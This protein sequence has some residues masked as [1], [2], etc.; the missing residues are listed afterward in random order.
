MNNETW[1]PVAGYAGLYEVS[2][3]GRVRRVNG[4]VLRLSPHM[5]GGLMAYLFRDGE[6]RSFLAHRLVAEAFLGPAPSAAHVVM[7]RNGDHRDNRAVNLAW[8][9]RCERVGL[10]KVD[11]EAVRAIRRAYAAG[12]KTQAEIGQAYGIGQR[13]VGAIVNRERWAHVE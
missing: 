12:G 10:R 8:V 5:R 2:D 7:H 6:R 1:R 3:L 9:R 4:K 13:A 11:A